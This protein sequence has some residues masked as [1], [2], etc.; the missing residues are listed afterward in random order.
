[1][2]I[3]CLT[4][5]TVAVAFFSASCMSDESF[6]TSSNHLLVYSHDTV[7]VDTVFSNVSSSTR[8]F[9]VYNK[10]GEGIKLANVKLAGGNQNGFRVN[11]DG[12]YLGQT[13][14]YQVNNLEVR[15]GDSLRV[16]VEFTAPST[17][18]HEPQLCQDD[19]VF[20][21]GS[22]VEQKVHLAAWAWEALKLKNLVIDKDTLLSTSTP[23]IVYGK[24]SVNKGATFRISGG[25]SLYFHDGAGIDV[26]GTLLCEGR[27]GAEVLMR[28]DR[29][30]RMFDYL[31]YD[32]VSGQWDG[33]HFY[34]ES[35]NNRLQYVELH[36][37]NTGVQCDSK[38]SLVIEH[39]TIH[40][41]KGYGVSAQL[42][43]LKL[44]DSQLSNSLNDCL[45]I[46]GGRVN[47]Q[48]CTI[49]QFY[50]FDSARGYAL[51]L[52]NS[53]GPLEEFTCDN[54][55]ITGYAK[56]VVSGSNHKTTAFN[57]RFSSCLLRTVEPSAENSSRYVDVQYENVD[58]TIASGKKNFI[59][60]DERNLAY[61]FHLASSSLANNKGDKSKA[62]STDRTGMLREERPDIG[63]Y[64]RKQSDK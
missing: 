64:E 7:S 55:L 59:K 11:V 56:D 22:G 53:S 1:M 46:D 63:A 20:K 60:V 9:W 23:L 12:V 30:D 15:N 62:S 45:L 43:H 39:S 5:L 4:I 38:S 28:G 52:S 49:A 47:V 33:L 10:S 32:R 24:I 58:D 31:P 21:L 8:S 16:Y 36:G 35:V 25:T 14:G 48:G 18:Q 40:N 29:L 50:P 19:L 34:S 44:S 37:A 17:T 41:S 6:T 51:N 61:D 57:Y 2:R 42:A 27:K 13:A 54:S 26:K 3:F